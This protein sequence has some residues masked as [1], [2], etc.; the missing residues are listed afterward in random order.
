LLYVYAIL[1]G[2][3]RTALGRGIAGEPLRALRAGS[4]I[5]VVAR[6][7][8]PV[9]L[10][11]VTLRA[12][13]RIVRRIGALVPGILPVRFG[14][15]VTDAADLA[16]LLHPHR[17][18][19]SAALTLVTGREQMTI[20]VFGRHRH[21]PS[22]RAPRTRTGPSAGTRYLR[23]RARAFEVPEA[24]PVL[25]AVRPLVKSERVQP[26]D[27]GGLRAS[28]YHLI[29]RGQAKPYIARATRAASSLQDVRV[30]V[31]G[32]SPPYAFAW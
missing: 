9:Q 12:H 18:R 17:E 13:D 1:S 19:L 26:H 29:D 6:V 24:K 11:P 21:T 20:R 15:H 16:A 2:V 28:I 3:P 7:A 10:S 32:P 27:A 30:S 31:S 23:D 14:T 8:A 5:A 4:V 22:R 25:S